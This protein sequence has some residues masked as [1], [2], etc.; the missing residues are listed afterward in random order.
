MQC[1]AADHTN[2][3]MAVGTGFAVVCLECIPDEA[4]R[5]A[6]V[7]ALKG[8]EIVDIT[9]QQMGAFC[10]NVLEL[11]D[12]RGLPVLAA[13]SQAAAAFT[14]EQTA[15]LLRHVAVRGW[16]GPACTPKG[17]TALLQTLAVSAHASLLPPHCLRPLTGRCPQAIYHAPVET[18]E[19][20]GGGGVRCTLAEV[21]GNN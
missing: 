8:K 7:E 12:R 15:A 13:S 20:V 9:L 5:A 19:S 21:F 6:V 17:T 2:V 14:P 11:R 10:G 18:L 4:E 1:P 16:L 3:L